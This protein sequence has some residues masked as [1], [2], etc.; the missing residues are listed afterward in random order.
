LGG[1]KAGAS[2][3]GQAGGTAQASG[4]FFSLFF[5]SSSYF[6]LSSFL[7]FLF[8]YLARSSHLGHLE[9]VVPY[10]SYILECSYIII[11]I[12]TKTIYK[13]RYV[14]S[15]PPRLERPPERQHTRDGAGGGKRNP[16]RLEVSFSFSSLSSYQIVRNEEHFYW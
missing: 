2:C 3:R 8:R 7:S 9:N 4:S 14:L 6:F 1:T 5:S 10:K 15:T 11:V 13:M 12:N 16:S